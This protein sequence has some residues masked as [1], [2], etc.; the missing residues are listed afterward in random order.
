[1]QKQLCV[2]APDAVAALGAGHNLAA[3]ECQ[4]QFKGDFLI[5]LIR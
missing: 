2:E 1:M 5:F 3:L 4:H